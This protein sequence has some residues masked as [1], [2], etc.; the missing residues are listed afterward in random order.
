MDLSFFFLSAVITWL[1]KQLSEV[2]MAKKL[3]TPASA[4][5]GGR[6]AVSPHAVVRQSCKYQAAD[7]LISC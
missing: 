7:V 2:Q 3:D 5:G 4:H 6:A 1:N